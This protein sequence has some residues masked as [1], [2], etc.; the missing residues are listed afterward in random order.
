M[1]SERSFEGRV[2]LITGAGSG[3]GRA[4]AVAFAREGARL[5]LCDMNTE[6]L[7]E[8]VAQLGGAESWT[9]RVNVAAGAE[10]EA[11]VAGAVER[12]GRLDCAVNAAGVKAAVKPLGD[13]SETEFDQVMDINSKGVWLCM[14]YEIKAMLQNGGGAIVNLASGA[15]ILAVSHAGS[16]T[17]SKH[18]VVGLTRVGALDYGKAGIR[19]NAVCPGYT[20]TPMALASLQ[21]FNADEQMAASMHPIGRIAEPSEQA[22]AILYLCSD[23][24]S[25]ITGHAM[26]VDGGYTIQ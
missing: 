21:D 1:A 3:I 17:A 9:M 24:A 6:G 19:I 2:A 18:A 8:T 13:Y 20:R 12:F 16:Y 11:F 25:F 26:V 14:K 5:A 15:G 22:D 10:V 4:T 23:R 7:K